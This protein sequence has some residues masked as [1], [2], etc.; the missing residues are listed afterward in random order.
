MGGTPEA[1]DSATARGSTSA[2]ACGGTSASSEAELGDPSA[3]D[4]AR[5]RVGVEGRMAGVADYQVEYE[6][7]SDE[8]WRDVYVNYRQ[9]SHL[10]VQAGKFKLPFS[11]DENTSSAN[12]DFVYR[13]RAATQLAP[14]RDRG[15]MVHGRVLN[16]LQYEAGLFN[17]DGGE[18]ANGQPGPC[19]RRHDDRRTGDRAAVPIVEVAPERSAVRRGVHRQRRP[20]GHRGASGPDG[21][22]RAV[23][24]V[25]SVGARVAAGASGSKRDGVRDPSRSRP[26]TSASRPS[27]LGRAWKTPICLRSSA[28]GWYVSGTWLATG[29]KKASGAD[30]P[31]RPIFRGGFG[32]LE[33]AARLEALGFGSTAGR[34]GCPRRAPGRTSCSATAIARRR[35]ASTGTRTAES[36]SRGISSARCSPIRLAVRCR[37][38]RAS[39]ARSFSVQ[40][41]VSRTVLRCSVQKSLQ[42]HHAVSPCSF[43]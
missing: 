5:R 34:R 33:F 28:T 10:Q 37:R 22:R 41:S 39:G 9:F 17:R 4:V 30:N 12:L 42:V 36:R 31:R 8:H 32:S 21:A 2:R 7:S 20:R 26:N 24:P 15:V 23:L 13:S 43:A 19:V 6:F 11:L 38:S 27:A 3:F 16:V 1:A 25:R 40:L 29:E 18:R 14:G 35:L